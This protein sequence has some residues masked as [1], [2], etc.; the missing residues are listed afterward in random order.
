MDSPDRSPPANE[1]AEK[2]ALPP[3]LV[4][5]FKEHFARVQRIRRILWLGAWSA[6]LTAG[7]DIVGR[8]DG[9]Y[10][11]LAA[12]WIARATLIA[13]VLVVHRRLG[14]RPVVSPAFVARSSALLFVAGAF[15]IAVFCARSGGLASPDAAGLV[16][17]LAAQALT[18]PADPVRGAALLGVTTAAFT[19]ALVGLSAL[20]FGRTTSL[21]DVLGWKIFVDHVTLI[22]ISAGLFLSARHAFLRPERPRIGGR[23]AGRYVL[24]SKLGAGGMGE[25]WSAYHPDLKRHVAVKVLRADC[26]VPPL[27]SRF[28]RE[29]QAMTLLSHP[30]TVRILDCGT[31]DE[32]LLYY[33]MEL[34]DGQNLGKLV[35][36][37]G[38]LSPV[39]AIHIVRQAARALAE[40]HSRGIVHRDIK[41]SNILITEMGGE[42]D[43]VKLLDFGIAKHGVLGEPSTLTNA[44]MLIGT[45][46][47]MSPEQAC[48]AQVDSRSDIYA[49]GAVL[50]YALT[51][52]PLFS[53][54][55]SMLLAAHLSGVPPVP[56]AYSP[57]FI[58]P[59]LDVVVRTCL[60]KD[61]SQRFATALELD[62]ALAAVPISREDY[63]SWSARPPSP[64]LMPMPSLTPADRDRATVRPGGGESG[65]RLVPR[66]VRPPLFMEYATEHRITLAPVSSSGPVSSPAPLSTLSPLS[67]SGPVSVTG[68][69]SVSF[70]NG[71]ASEKTV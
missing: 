64:S 68:P 43:F 53:G 2:E 8:A 49:L 3:N 63:V 23:R 22:V 54:S 67:G 9:K 66:F 21:S 36:R 41:P 40:A 71:D 12:L 70:T 24:K 44:G 65:E 62:A 26:M 27:V 25:V 56:S 1:S 38:P 14:R 20:H 18:L 5:A 33:A 17:V 45:P 11:S 4:P 61:P 34:L 19:S 39:R 29:I 37:E 57:H 59:A 16:L 30:N 35:E 47:Y 13:L 69:V 48:S 58:H 50:F 6:L 10:D 60:S 46:A 15:V 55:A 51:G 32:G 28:E 52:R 42:N 31:T 7:A